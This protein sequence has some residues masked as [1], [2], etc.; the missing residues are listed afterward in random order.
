[1]FRQFLILS[2]LLINMQIIVGFHKQIR[3]LNQISKSNNNKIVSPNKLSMNI[4]I[5][6]ST[7]A[8]PA[9][10]AL[11][12][13]NE[14]VTHRWYQHEEFNKNKFLLNI[15]KSL[16]GG[17]YKFKGGGHVEH[18]AE[19]LDDMSLKQDE[20]WKKSS[21]AVLL[22]NDKF[23]GTAFHW[24]VTFLMGLQ[25]LITGIPVFKYI[26][27]FSVFSTI[28][29]IIPSLLLHALV[30]NALHPH[31]HGLPDVNIFEGAPSRILKKFRS[32]M[33]FKYLYQNHEGH[34]VLGGQANYNVCCPLFDH[35]LG[36][37][38]EESLWRPKVKLVKQNSM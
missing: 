30:W 36:T 6:Q 20:V 8:V 25:M 22:D 14:Y 29:M 2:L 10:Y 38:R 12:S 26:L 27:G 17:I 21:A 19:T 13:I 7:A 9:M 28:S 3:V 37:Y 16:N 11:M 33:I 1:M 32:S 15:A 31:M 4:G 35:V 18:H 34:H 5:I 23:R 24:K